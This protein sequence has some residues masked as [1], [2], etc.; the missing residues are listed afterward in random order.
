MD[1]TKMSESISLLNLL[2]SLVC[3]I[4]YNNPMR[5]GYDMVL[6]TNPTQMAFLGTRWAIYAPQQLELDK[7]A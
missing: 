4:A 1:S 2:T 7:L 3:V 6:A 5:R